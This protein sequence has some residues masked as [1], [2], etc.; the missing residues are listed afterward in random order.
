MTDEL[1]VFTDFAWVDFSEY[2]SLAIDPY[3]PVALDIET[4]FTDTAAVGSGA[5]YELDPEWT[6]M[7]RI[8]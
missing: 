3:G 7:A 1:T 6:L 2:E 8:F 5:E 4:H